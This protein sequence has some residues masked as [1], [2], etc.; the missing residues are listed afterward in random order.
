MAYWSKYLRK[1]SNCSKEDCHVPTG[2][3]KDTKLIIR[4]LFILLT[5]I[6]IGVGIV[7]HQ[8]ATLT[9]CPAQAGLESAVIATIAN[10]VPPIPSKIDFENSQMGYW[11]A[12]W[13]QQFVN[14][15]FTAKKAAGEYWQQGKPYVEAAVRI[16]KLKT[17]QAV[18]QIDKYIREY[19]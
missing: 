8:M 17:M 4:G 6:T 18:E 12:V 9:Q 13:H 2:G 15:A 10:Y 14:E 19:R 1:T 11:L 7:E 5:I 16:L 3:G